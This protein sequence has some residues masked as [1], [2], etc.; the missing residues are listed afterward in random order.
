[1]HP[2]DRTGWG[3]GGDPPAVPR[4]AGAAHNLAVPRGGDASP[5]ADRL[6]ALPDF[7]RGGAVPRG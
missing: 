1:V 2:I 6:P 4:A 5:A 3:R 7:P